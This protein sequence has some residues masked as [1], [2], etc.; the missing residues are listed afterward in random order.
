[1]VIWGVAKSRRPW[2]FDC[3]IYNREGKTMNTIRLRKHQAVRYLFGAAA[4]SLVGFGSAAGAA[5]G[6]AVGEFGWFG[7]GKAYEMEKGHFFWV[8]EFSGTFFSD[9]GAGG[10]V[11]PGGGQVPGMAGHG[12]QQQAKP[13]WR[14]LYHHRPRR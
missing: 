9:K 4:L 6:K 12:F 3:S 10:D 13:G 8:G 11:P 1:M 7:V 2:V 5:D 14:D